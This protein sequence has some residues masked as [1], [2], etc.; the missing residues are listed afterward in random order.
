M[1][2]LG[3]LNRKYAGFNMKNIEVLVQEV[4]GWNLHKDGR[5]KLWFSGY[6]TEKRTINDLL[7][8]LVCFSKDENID[9]KK[10]SKWTK[11]ITGHYALIAEVADSWC[12]SSVD[13]IGSIPLYEFNSDKKYIITNCATNLKSTSNNKILQSFLEISMSGYTL[14]RK[15]IYK[16]INR[17]LSGECS[18]W[19]NGELYREYFYEYL[20][21]KVLTRGGSK[22]K[23]ELTNVILSVLRRTVESINGRQIVVPLSAGND[24]RL[25][26]SG[27]KELGQKNVLCF[28]YGRQGNYE[29]KTSQKVAKRLGYKWIYIPDSFRSKRLFFLSKTYKR[30]VKEF[31]SY[32]S[33]PNTQEIYEVYKLNLLNVI[34]KDA[35]VIN[36]N[37][38]DFISGGHIPFDV[39][40]CN[41]KSLLDEFDWSA[42]LE[43]HYS[44]WRGLRSHVNDKIIV[45][46]LNN[47]AQLRCKLSNKKEVH[48]YAV[49]ECMEAIGRQSRFVMN[50]QRAYEFIGHEWRSPLWDNEF[51]DFWEG[52]PPEY[53]VGQKLYKEVLNENNWGGVWNDIGVNN[54]LIRPFPLLILRSITKFFVAPFGKKIWHT[55]DNN[56]FSYWI[57]PSY[58]RTVE[59]YGKVLFD[60]RGQRNTISWLADQFVKRNGFKG[61]LD[62]SDKV[63][64][65]I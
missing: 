54:K 46:E 19:V 57:H 34:D 32:S 62:V 20:P 45:S 28:S 47:I 65:K 43:K 51:L 7:K 38:G 30:Y 29:M 35:V 49:M 5:V 16:N 60:R 23:E 36:G 40:G 39:K 63:Q 48:D 13:R 8:E 25:I 2:W 11:G 61:V 26:V 14:G 18:L 33:V 50:Q 59:S 6:L 22:L 53:K 21:N 3:N 31:E 4:G 27:L 41:K 24:S 52:V 55:V 37:T 9:I 58:A 56:I 15:T 12:F 10:L 1:Q 44:V 42:F 17:F 64:K